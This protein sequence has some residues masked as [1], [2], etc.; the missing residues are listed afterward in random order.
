VAYRSIAKFG[1]NND[2]SVERE[3]VGHMRE[4]CGKGKERTSVRIANMLYCLSMSNMMAFSEIVR[5]TL[6]GP[7]VGGLI[8]IARHG[9]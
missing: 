7:K 6:A 1:G 2:D 8:F 4:G 9:S 5:H 3:R